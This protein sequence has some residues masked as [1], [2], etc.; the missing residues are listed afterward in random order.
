MQS[1]RTSS[2]DP[3]KEVHIQADAKNKELTISPY[4]S[5]L[6]YLDRQ[7]QERSVKP[8]QYLPRKRGCIFRQKV[9]LSVSE[10]ELGSLPIQRT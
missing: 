6:L 7:R 2:L 3:G 10:L 5:S 9:P 4:D 1:L 8:D